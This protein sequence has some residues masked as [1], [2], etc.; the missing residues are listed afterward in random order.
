MNHQRL[1]SSFTVSSLIHLSLIPVAALI[2][3]AKPLK[4]IT[5][6]VE[7]V[8]VP[9]MEQPKKSKSHRLSPRQN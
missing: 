8:H 5:V 6:P 3:H 9:R 2:M 7:L 1:V 4:P